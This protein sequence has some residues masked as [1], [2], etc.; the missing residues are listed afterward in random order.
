MGD[1]HLGDWGLQIGQIITELKERQPDLPYFDPAITDGYPE[2][3]PF[4][5]SDLEEIYPCA[6]K[7]SKADEAFKAAAQAATAELQAGRPG[8]GHCGSIS[9]MFLSP[10]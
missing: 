4:T 6:S 3:P 9:S 8:Y 7:K 10:T 1:V 5:I 2:E